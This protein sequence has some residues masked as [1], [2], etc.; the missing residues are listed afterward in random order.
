ME[1]SLHECEVQHPELFLSLG[2]TEPAKG[3][4]ESPCVLTLLSSVLERNIDKNEQILGSMKVKEIFTI[5]HGL[6]VPNIS[7]RS[8]VERIFTYSKCSPSCFVLAYIYIDRF[9]QLPDTYL[10]SLNVHRLLIT[11]IVV[12]AKFID[13]AFFNNAYYARVGGVST[14]EM[15]RMELSFLFS[16]GFKLQ[17]SIGTFRGYC[18]QLERDS[19]SYQIEK[20]IYRAKDMVKVSDSYHQQSVQRCS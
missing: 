17:V 2:L 4:L 13:D 10:T 14:R 7:I 11:S 20:P 8:Y 15:N 1:S 16:L 5:F 19:T 3:V 9:L 12:A 18:L 6:R